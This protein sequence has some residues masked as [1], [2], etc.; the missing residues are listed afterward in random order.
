M[1]SQGQT[2]ITPSLHTQLQCL[3]KSILSCLYVLNGMVKLISPAIA[4]VARIR[5]YAPIDKVKRVLSEARL[6]LTHQ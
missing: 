4:V 2:P 5:S 6:E 3:Q 1:K